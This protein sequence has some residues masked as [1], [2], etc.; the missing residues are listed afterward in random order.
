MAESQPS[1][2]ENY[3]PGKFPSDVLL[4]LEKTEPILTQTD[5]RFVL[6]PLTYPAV[7]ELYKKCTF[8]TAEE[9]DLG[10][11]PSDWKNRL[12]DDEKRFVGHVVAFLAAAG[13]ITQ[14]NLA[15]RFMTDVTIPEA[16]AFYGFQIALQNI[17]SEIYSRLLDTYVEEAEARERL[18]TA[19]ETVPC[20]AKKAQWALK[21]INSDKPFAERLAAFI[22][23]QSIFRSGPFCAIFWFKTRGLLPGLTLSNEFISRDEQLHCQHACTLFNMLQH[24]PNDSVVQQIFRE[25]VDIE[26]EFITETM[27]AT[28]IRIDA[29]HM[30]QHVEYVANFW[31]SVIRVPP[32]GNVFITPFNWMSPIILQSTASVFDK[33]SSELI[34]SRDSSHSV[35]TPTENA[36]IFELSDDF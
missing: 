31:L 34:K 17:H 3:A 27:P 8:W 18:F 11:D 10:S 24:K 1:A 12:T 26:K 7:W 6:F 33:R 21:W 23:G 14:E 9:I 13:G 20:V 4:R 2:M 29:E 28:L 22:A 36:P 19:V 25:A 5:S 15:A 30:K 32:L 16:R 35:G